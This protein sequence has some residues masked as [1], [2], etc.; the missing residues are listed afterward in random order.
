MRRA[1]RAAGALLLLLGLGFTATAVLRYPY[2]SPNGPGAGFLPFWLGLVLAALAVALL[3]GARRG[4]DAPWLPAGRDRRR[5]AA[6]LAASVLLLV[7]LPVLG[8]A[9]A[10][11]LFLAAL[12][13]FERHSWPATL[14]IAAG[15]SLVN[16]L[17]FA[18]WLRVPFPT[19]LLGF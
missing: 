4:E 6:R 7:G 14:G 17:V 8:M 9:L 2:Q 1:D 11:A 5:L 3:A 18:W 10:T 15:V 19:G 16:Y 12:L 13:R